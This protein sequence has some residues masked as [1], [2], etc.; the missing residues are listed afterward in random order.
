MRETAIGRKSVLTWIRLR[1]LPRRARMEPRPGMPEFYREYLWRRWTEGCRSVKRLMAEI[2]PLG[3]VGGYAGLAK[4][5]ARW[6]YDAPTRARGRRVVDAPA[7]TVTRHV[8]PPV[9]AALLARPRALLSERQGET[10]DAL[11]DHCPG[12]TAMRRLV[13]SF[14]TI[15][16]V[17][18][19]ATL[20]Q[21]MAR[22]AATDID[23][24]QRF[25]R[26]LRHDLGAVEGAVAERW[27]NGPVE[28]HINRLKTL[29]RQM[30]GRAGVELLRARLLPLATS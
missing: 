3:Y 4:L 11:K 10:V 13:L 23:A 26:R 7:T 30:Y 22:A 5:V 28:G 1:E 16:R 12:F 2:Q 15:L 9:A 6:R 18:T 19:V 17:G 14:G 24:T 27:S 25:V 29:R 21:W 20:H 8:S